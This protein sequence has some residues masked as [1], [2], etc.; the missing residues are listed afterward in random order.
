MGKIL[1]LDERTKLRYPCLSSATLQSKLLELQAGKKSLEDQVE[2]LRAAK[3]E[4][5]RPEKEAK[6]QHR[7]LWEGRLRGGSGLRLSVLRSS[8]DM[9][10]SLARCP[11]IPSC[12][13]RQ[14]MCSPGWPSVYYSP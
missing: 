6:D 13:L 7:K 11:C 12:F 2:T 8:P 1:G 10:P 3:E 5:E 4:A 14:D 9:G